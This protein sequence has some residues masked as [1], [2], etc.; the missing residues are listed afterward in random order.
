M[1]CEEELN[2]LRRAEQDLALFRQQSSGAGTT[3]PEPEPLPAHPEGSADAVQRLAELT[4]AV[5]DRQDAY[6]SCLGHLA[7]VSAIEA[8]MRDATGKPLGGGAGPPM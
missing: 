6:N 7:S 1:S 3:G 8:L 5:Q 2:A 4:A